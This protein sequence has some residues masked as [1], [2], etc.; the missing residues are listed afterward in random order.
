MGRAGVVALLLDRGADASAK[1]SRGETA[2]SLAKE[3]GYDDVV[4]VLEHARARRAR[5]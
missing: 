4:S 1:D 3:N 2:L 5:E